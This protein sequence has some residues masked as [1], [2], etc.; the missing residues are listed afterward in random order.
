MY[1]RTPTQRIQFY[2]NAILTKNSYQNAYNH[3]FALWVNSL[4][5]NDHLSSRS[6]RVLNKMKHAHTH[7][8]RPTATT[9][10][11][12]RPNQNITPIWSKKMKRRKK[13]TKT[14][15]FLLYMLAT[16]FICDDSRTPLSW[17]YVREWAIACSFLFTWVVVV[18]ASVSV[19]LAYLFVPFVCLFLLIVSLHIV[20]FFFLLSSQNV[21]DCHCKSVH[22]PKV[23]NEVCVDVFFF[24]LVRVLWRML[25]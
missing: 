24:L 12:P 16:V 13:T 21:F 2:N 17:Q 8:P 3:G 23:G 18:A 20:V 7:T 6:K 11:T 14:V 19:S 15:W 25:K 4:N 9:T 10:N 1:T 5:N 22:Q